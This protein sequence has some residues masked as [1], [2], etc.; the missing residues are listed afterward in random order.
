MLSQRSWN[1]SCKVSVPLL[2]N[3]SGRLRQGLWWYGLRVDWM[4]SSQEQQRLDIQ[5][6]ITWILQFFLRFLHWVR[7]KFKGKKNGLQGWT[8]GRERW[9]SIR[10]K[11]WEK[12]SFGTGC[13]SKANGEQESEIKVKVRLTLQYQCIQHIS[14]ASEPKVL[15]K[16]ILWYWRLKKKQVKDTQSTKHLHFYLKSN[17]GASEIAL[18]PVRITTFYGSCIQR[19]RYVHNGSGWPFTLT[20]HLIWVQICFTQRTENWIKYL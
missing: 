19:Q 14:T 6:N 1:M 4:F 18:K 2:S 12:R 17:M 8:E 15:L 16:C 9:E 5:Y 11:V 3:A 20:A 10:W 13:I 7:V